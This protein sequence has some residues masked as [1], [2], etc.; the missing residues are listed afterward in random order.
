[1][2]DMRTVLTLVLLSS[3]AVAQTTDGGPD[4]LSAMGFGGLH[5]KGSSEPKKPKPAS[6][7]PVVTGSLDKEVIR[8]VL[9]ACRKDVVACA[10]ASDGGVSEGTLTVHFVISP[11]GQVSAS[12]VQQTT[13]D[14]SIG[15]CIA[16]V[17]KK[18]TFPAPRGG[19]QV[20]VNYPYRFTNATP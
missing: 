8:R 9:I 11:S 19:G 20:I 16:L 17:I 7:V 13:L 2:R 15:Q 4:S 10:M 5:L 3:A 12:A 6:D 18:A 14:E 1:M